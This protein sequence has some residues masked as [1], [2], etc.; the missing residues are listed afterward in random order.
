MNFDPLTTARFFTCNDKQARNRLCF[1]WRL[2][3]GPHGDLAQQAGQPLNDARD[4]GARVF[5]DDLIAVEVAVRETKLDR[6]ARSVVHLPEI[7]AHLEKKGL[8]TLA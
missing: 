5:W 3:D 8:Y 4:L 6:L 1:S 7:A 2:I